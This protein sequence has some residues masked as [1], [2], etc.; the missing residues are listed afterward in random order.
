MSLGRKQV[1]RSRTRVD[2]ACWTWLIAFGTALVWWNL[3]SGY[4]LRAKAIGLLMV[5]GAT[6]YVV[7]VVTTLYG[8]GSEA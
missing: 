7:D 6:I 8:D 5:L 3:Q 1:L 2:V 4:P